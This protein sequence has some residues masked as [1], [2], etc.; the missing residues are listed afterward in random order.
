MTREE[1]NEV[2][3]KYCR[4]RECGDCV[5][6]KYKYHV[7]GGCWGDD[8]TDEHINMNYDLVMCACGQSDVTPEVTADDDCLIVK[9]KPVPGLDRISFT[10][11]FDT[12]MQRR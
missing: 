3:R 4:G 2:I 11:D 9:I 5:I 6:N 1:K 7:G 8:C 12:I 10:V